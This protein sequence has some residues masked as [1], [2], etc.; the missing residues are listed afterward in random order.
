[1]TDDQKVIRSLTQHEN[2]DGKKSLDFLKD[3]AN[4]VERILFAG[5]EPLIMDE[6]YQLLEYLI[7]NKNFCMLSYHT[8]MSKLQYKNWNVLNMWSKWPSNKILIMPSLDEIGE[9][10]ENIR[11]G[12]IWEEVE[13]NLKTM[14]D[15][16]IKMQPNITINAMN[17]NRIPELITYLYENKIITDQ[18]KGVNFTITS[19]YWP[20]YMQINVLPDSFRAETKAKILNFINEFKNKTSWDLTGKLQ[21]TLNL[22][23]Q[24]FEKDQAKE[25]I[26]YTAKLDQIRNESTYK[27]MPELECIKNAV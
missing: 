26:H 20:S 3:N 2:I 14:V 23:D 16:G 17:V 15:A 27:T 10:A 11:H 19:V 13:N 18:Y 24:P 22:L 6:H 5:G 9:R 7:D 21:L 25:F 1:M 8:N 12:T 4:R